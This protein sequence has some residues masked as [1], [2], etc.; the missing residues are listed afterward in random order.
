IKKREAWAGDDKKVG[1]A[2]LVAIK[3]AHR[4]PFEKFVDMYFPGCESFIMDSV[5][6]LDGPKRA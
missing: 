5:K 2:V 4:A 3:A 1:A 6:F